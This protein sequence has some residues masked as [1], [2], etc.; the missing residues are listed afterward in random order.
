M[1]VAVYVEYA[2]AVVPF[3][4]PSISSAQSRILSLA[5]CPV[6]LNALSYVDFV[7]MLVVN[8]AGHN[9]T[10]KAMK[11]IHTNSFFIVCFLSF[12]LLFLANLRS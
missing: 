1:S 9:W 6:H 2:S 11:I 8:A 10:R 5:G 4:E 7:V 12:S 3:I